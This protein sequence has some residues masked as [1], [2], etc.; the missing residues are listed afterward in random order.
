M[1]ALLW[2]AIALAILQEGDSVSVKPG[3]A[4]VLPQLETQDPPFGVRLDR[5]HPW[6]GIVVERWRREAPE[7]DWRVV[8]IDLEVANPGYV[9]SDF[10]YRRESADGPPLQSARAHTTVDFLMEHS[11]RE[12]VDLAVNGVAFYPFPAFW[13]HPVFLE[14][15]VWNKEDQTRDTIPGSVMLGLFPGRAVIDS[16]ENLR[17][18]APEVALG[19]FLAGGSSPSKGVAVWNGQ[20]IANGEPPAAR[21]LVGTSADGRILI[22]IVADGYHPG[23]SIGFTLDEAAQVLL[24]AGAQDAIFLDGG[25]SAT[26]VARGDDGEPALLNRPAGLQKTPGTLRYVGASLGFTNLR[27]TDE[28]LP[29]LTDWQAPAHVVRWNQVVVWW[30]VQKVYATTVILGAC[31][32]AAGGLWGGRRIWKRRRTSG[33]QTSADPGSAD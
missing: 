5:S 6:K 16:S 1:T 8:W 32:L 7:V 4:T 30:R 9:V 21:T 28:P 13:R 25:G 29:M 14:E 18:A 3:A 33:N 19:A 15:P 17:A 12:R 23:V 2:A 31:L 10:F 27:R 24:A 11:G 22:L 26:L 20:P